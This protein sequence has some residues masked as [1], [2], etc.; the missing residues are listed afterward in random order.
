M[1]SYG[2]DVNDAAANVNTNKLSEKITFLTR[3]LAKNNIVKQNL[4]LVLMT[5]E[6]ITMMYYILRLADIKSLQNG[7]TGIENFLNVQM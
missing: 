5:M 2:E 1:L 6:Y 3:A 4:Y 7:F